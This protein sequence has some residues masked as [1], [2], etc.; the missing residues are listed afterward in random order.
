VAYICPSCL[1]HLR[2]IEVRE[3]TRRDF[4]KLFNSWPQGINP[5]ASSAIGKGGAA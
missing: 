2:A 5:G 1:A 4:A 3:I